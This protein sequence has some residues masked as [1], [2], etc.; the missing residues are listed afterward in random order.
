MKRTLAIILSLVMLLSV[1]ILPASAEVDEKRAKIPV[2]QVC[3]DS[4]KLY[5]ADGEQLPS[6]RDL[7]ALLNKDGEKGKKTEGTDTTSPVAEAAKNILTPF[8][9]Q[10][11]LFDNWEPYYDAVY[12]EISDLT[13]KMLPDKNGDIT[14]GSDIHKND[15]AKMAWMHTVDLTG[16]NGT[17]GIDDYRFFYDWRKS[18]LEIADELKEHI[19]GVMAVTHTDKVSLVGKCVGSAVV[20]SY[21]AKYGTDHIYG[22]ALDG[23]TVNGS[24]CFS[25]SISGKFCFDAL[26]IERLLYDLESFGIVNL[27]DFITDTIDLAAKTGAIDFIKEDFKNKVYYHILEGITSA[28]ALS[29]FFAMPCYWAAVK[30]EDYDTALNYVFGPEGSEK[31]QEYKGLI[32]K[33]ENYHNE[34]SVKLPELM[35][36]VNDNCNLCIISKYGTQIAPICE[37]RNLISDTSATVKTVSFGATTSEV[38]TTL[39]EEY[40]AGRVALGYGKYISPDKQIDAS[41]CMFPDCTWFVKGP[42]HSDW[43]NQENSIIMNVITADHQVTVDETDCTQFVVVPV[44]EEWGVPMTAENCHT[45]AWSEASLKYNESLN[46]TEGKISLLKSFLRWLRSLLRLLIEKVFMK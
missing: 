31:R 5:T 6:F 3:G 34:V 1:C 24:E 37:S 41:T 10:G 25:E 2:I 11:I 29:T 7:E 27:D 21:V 8:I 20:M 44:N 19:D 40:I 9:I 13:S 28:L 26:A 42:R 15:R 39:S 17:N 4:R 43:T 12:K 30:P 32:E 38:N 14:D 33:I 36:Q 45:E 23:H 35:K 18:P 46:T 16:A 22:L